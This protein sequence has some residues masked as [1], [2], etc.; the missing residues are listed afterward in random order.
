MKEAQGRLADAKK[1]LAE[2]HI[3][4]SGFDVVGAGL[5]RSYRKARR[6]LRQ[7]YDEQTDEA[8]HD[9]RKG[10]Q[11]HWRQMTLLARAWPDY[12]GARASEARSALATSGR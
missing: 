8:F 1:R 11:A 10:T 4:G 2:L 9:W 7:A 12:L 3:D 5:E 6:A